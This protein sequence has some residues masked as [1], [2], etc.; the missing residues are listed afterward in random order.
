MKSFDA[1]YVNKKEVKPINPVIFQ[2]AADFAA[3]WFDAALSSGLPRGQYVGRGDKPIRLFVANHLEKFIPM[4][5][6]IAIDMLKPTSNCN[7]AMRRML[8]DALM[9]PLNDPEM[10]QIG[11]TNSKQQNEKMISDA[12]K[13]YDKNKIKTA[14]D[15]PMAAPIRKPTDLKSSTSLN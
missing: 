10:M 7:E 6:S 11:K 15:A 13:N 14:I 3:V 8:Y 9:D 1:S 5:V 12:I 4:A 2:M